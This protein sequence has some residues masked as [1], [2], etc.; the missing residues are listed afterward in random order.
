VSWSRATAAA[1]GLAVLSGRA[2]ADEQTVAAAE[3]KVAAVKTDIVHVKDLVERGEVTAADR[4]RQLYSEGE[5]QFLLED[6]DGAASKLI[7]AVGTPEYRGD[8]TYPQAVYYLA[9]ALFRLESYADSKKYFRVAVQVMDPAKARRYQDALVRLIRLSDLTGDN[10]GVDQYYVAARKIGGLR[11]ELTYLYAKWTA[12]REDIPL[13]ERDLRAATAFAD[14]Q[15]GQ[16]FY[17]QALYFR[18]ALLVELGYVDNAIPLFQALTLLKE[19]KNE[20]KIAELRDLGHLAL[21]RIYVE[22]KKYK[23]AVDEYKAI[24]TSSPQFITGLYERAQTFLRMGSYPE[25]LRTAET[26][27][28][29][30]KDSADAPDSALFQAN[31]LLKMGEKDPASF[32]KATTAFKNVIQAY[33]PVRDQIRS[34]VERPNPVEYFDEFLKRDPEA[35]FTQQLPKVA[36]GFVDSNAQVMVAKELQ[37]QIVGSHK[38]IDE[39]NVLEKK[40][41]DAVARGGL[42]AFP[43][44]AEANS[45]TLELTNKLLAIETDVIREQVEA[46]RTELDKL[47]V[48]LPKTQE[49]TE[50]RLT[51]FR[52]IISDLELS[53]FQVRRQLETVQATL[54]GL[55]K[56]W[57]DTL[58]QQKSTP[59]EKQERVSDFNQWH[60]LVDQLDERRLAIDRAIQSERAA[61]VTAAGG[62]KEEDDLRDRYRQQFNEMKQIVAQALPHVQPG[63]RPLLQRLTTLRDTIEDGE[64]QLDQMR[65]S[66]RGKVQ[67]RLERIRKT[68]LGEKVNLD[69]E[70]KGLGGLTDT[71]AQLIGQI[72]VDSF[73]KVEQDF[74]GVVLHGDVGLV[75]VAWSKKE[76]HTQTIENY[77]KQK[78]E[79]NRILEDRFK[80]VLGDA[81]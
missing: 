27:V 33:A 11:P 25:A 55:D 5:T 10:Q 17:P 29:L 28:L 70:A 6:Y 75:D 18:S 52:K 51:K 23:D 41:Q 14:L 47:F 73:R 61:L 60:Q 79:A 67:G 64:T 74:Y 49:D 72:A 68:L 59:A 77:A 76:S 36:Q 26:L 78:E 21:G 39:G 1:L 43:Q 24:P 13:R 45:R 65:E 66:V 37:K 42:A 63:N 31:L 12:N 44:L 80:E 71:S 53:L 50:E 20:P 54:S 30:G 7:D 46:E 3:A 8:P 81:E 2:R 56:Y 48:A 16:P 9:E 22:K 69:D 58:D 40:L 4:A 35:D 34:I 38:Q 15:P 32:E 57:H 19:Q 62:G